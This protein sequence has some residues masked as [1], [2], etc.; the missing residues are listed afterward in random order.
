MNDA[1]R[2]RRGERICGLNPDAQSAFQLERAPIAK[3]AHVLALDILHRDVMDS[4]HFVHV[5]DGADVRMIERGSES[6][7]SLESFQVAFFDR[8]FSRQHFDDD[9]A[10]ELLIDGFVY[11]PLSAGAELVSDFVVT[12]ELANHR[13]RILVRNRH[14]G[15]RRQPLL[16]AS[17]VEADIRIECW[18]SQG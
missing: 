4:V 17:Q 12:E 14:R 18:P 8:E 6:R 9:R 15:K 10:A 7:F 1:A 3:L 5:E 13:G 11:G 16:N 2:V